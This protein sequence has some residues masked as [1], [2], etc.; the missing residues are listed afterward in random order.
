VREGQKGVF[1]DT[2]KGKTENKRNYKGVKGYRVHQ[3]EKVP[4]KKP[5]KS[6]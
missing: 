2:L 6:G 4:Y 1:K 5:K 3:R